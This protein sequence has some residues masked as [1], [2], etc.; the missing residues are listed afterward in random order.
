MNKKWV[1]IGVV[2]VLVL[3]GSYW[4][5]KHFTAK[6]VAAANITS[7]AKMGDVSKVITATG[8]VNFPQAI[9]LTFAQAGKILEVNV[10]AGDTVEK[11]QVLA[12]IDSTKLE[13]AVL[14]AQAGVTSAKAKLQSVKDMFNAQTKA[15][16]QATLAGNQAKVAQAQDSLAQAKSNPETSAEALASKQA[17]VTSAQ[18]NVTSAQYDVKEQAQGPKSADLQSAQSGIDIAQIQLTSAQAE[19]LG[20]SIIAPMD[21][22]VVSAPLEL[23]QQ[24][25]AQSMITIAPAGDTLQVDASID[26][27]DIAQVKV[28]QIVDAT[29][30]AYLDVHNSGVVSVVAVQGTV[31][32]NVTTFVVTVKMDKASDLLLAGMNANISIVVAEAKNVLMVP[33]EAVKTRGDKK[34]VLIPTDSGTGSAGQADPAAQSST[35]P[36]S[37]PNTGMGMTAS[38]GQNVT[39]EI[40]LD[41]G[42]NV[43]IKSGIKEG[44]EVIIGT[45]STMA[46]KAA[47]GLFNLGGGGNRPAGGAGGNSG[48][49]APSGAPEK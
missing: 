4:T 30:D 22:V 42:T 41:D 34:S 31:V 47:S 46:A 2:G 25:D 44:Q 40:G 28:G 14:Q 35:N 20:S 19:V 5:Y 32:S 6:P 43:E 15:R 23:Y 21:A 26:Q 13:N 3:G 17:D 18:A 29:L 33:S 12:K 48:G 1:I 16:A 27:A 10:K 9:P 8:T 38:A 7:K 36:R 45:T 11:G 39:V 37:A 49:S 24:S